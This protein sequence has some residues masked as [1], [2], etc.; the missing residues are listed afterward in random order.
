MIATTILMMGAQVWGIAFIM[1]FSFISISKG[2]I[3]LI[4]WTLVGA[5]GMVCDLI[6][7][8]YYASASSLKRCHMQAGVL[9]LFFRGSFHRLNHEETGQLSNDTPSYGTD[10]RGVQV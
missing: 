3:V 5:V 8:L 6:S 1:S 4:C 7:G 10:H 2:V 9:M